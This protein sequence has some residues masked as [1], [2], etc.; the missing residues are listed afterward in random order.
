VVSLIGLKSVSILAH[1][2]EERKEIDSSETIMVNRAKGNGSNVDL[3]WALA[4]S[5]SQ[6][7]N[8]MTWTTINHILPAC[9]AMTSPIRTAM[10]RDAR[11]FSSSA[12]ISRMFLCTVGTVCMI[13]MLVLNCITTFMY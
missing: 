6:T 2:D 5:Q 12:Q 4:L 9:V 1:E 8:Q 13:P 10:E 7:A 11:A 3:P